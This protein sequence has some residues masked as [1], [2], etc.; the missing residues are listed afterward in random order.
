MIMMY[1]EYFLFKCI[2]FEYQFD[3]DR[4]VWE[5]IAMNVTLLNSILLSCVRIQCEYYSG[6]GV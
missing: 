4:D 5:F 6:K 2:S 3:F 1:L